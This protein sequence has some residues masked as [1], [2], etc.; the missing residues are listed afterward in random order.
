VSERKLIT[1][2]A[3]YFIDEPP[4]SRATV[5]AVERIV[6]EPAIRELPVAFDDD[7][8]PNPGMPRRTWGI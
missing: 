8:P 5:E 4:P 2:W 3:D 6:S 7:D 1:T